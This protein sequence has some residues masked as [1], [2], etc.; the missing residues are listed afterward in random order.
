MALTLRQLL[1]QRMR[2]MVSAQAIAGAHPAALLADRVRCTTALW[3]EPAFSQ[4]E[5]AAVKQRAPVIEYRP[6]NGQHDF[7]PMR[8][9]WSNKKVIGHAGTT[10]IGQLPVNQQ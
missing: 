7:M 3:L 8:L 5:P 10:D 9:R 2:H 6:A 1:I 4:A